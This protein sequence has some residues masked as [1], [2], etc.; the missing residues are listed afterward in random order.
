VASC[1]W[2]GSVY[3]PKVVL[4]MQ[5]NSLPLPLYSFSVDVIACGFFWCNKT[6]WAKG[7]ILT[8][9]IPIVSD[10][11]VLFVEAL[12]NWTHGEG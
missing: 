6:L 8:F 12:G 1:S 7:D 4:R 3:A 9:V 2:R 11:T 10:I 5:V